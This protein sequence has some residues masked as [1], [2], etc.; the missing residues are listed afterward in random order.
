MSKNT[1]PEEQTSDNVSKKETSSKGRS[2]RVPNP[3]AKGNAAKKSP[4]SPDASADGNAPDASTAASATA[5]S[6]AGSTASGPAKGK[7]SASKDANAQAASSSSKDGAKPSASNDGSSKDAPT[8]DD[9]GASASTPDSTADSSPD[10]TPEDASSPDAGEGGFAPQSFAG[11]P[12]IPEPD[13]SGYDESVSFGFGNVNLT[14]AE[15]MSQFFGSDTDY[16]ALP[17]PEVFNAYPP[18][19]QRKIMEWTDRDV[20]ARRD[21]E[22]RRQDELMRA[23][24]DHAR[25]KESFP[26]IIMVLAIVC[27]AVTGIVTGNPLF[28]LV[29]MIIPVVVI[30]ARIVTDDGSANSSSK[31]G[32]QR[33]FPW[34]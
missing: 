28:V 23:R 29:F 19:V 2:P 20:K 18:E 15:S 9:D 34:Q 16:A 5:D 10:S 24:V 21:D 11:I 8:A 32:G 33:K 27:G 6:E 1:K 26:V 7:D 13:L 14:E 3:F 31:P 30:V 22:S 17:S 12:P 4:A 25:R